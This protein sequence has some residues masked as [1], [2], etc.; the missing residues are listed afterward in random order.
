MLQTI[1]VSLYEKALAFREANTHNPQ[2]YETLK[3]V[4]QNGWANA[5]WCGSKECEAKVKD[6]TR[7]TTR[8]I[9]LDQEQGSGKCV[10]CGQHAT[11]K[12]IFARSY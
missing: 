4:V 8:C 2:D 7:A 12:V 6:E 9:P 5:W 1:Q 3:E 11:E 10:V